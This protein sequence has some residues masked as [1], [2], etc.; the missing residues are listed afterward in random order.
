MRL[1]SGLVRE[2]ALRMACQE[3][4]HRSGQGVL[5]HVGQRLG[6]DDVVTMPGPQQ[7]EEV[8]PALAGR[9]AEP[10]EVVVADLRADAIHRL[11][12]RPGVVDRDP[13]RAR[14]P[15]PQH[16][17]ALLEE[18]PLTLDQQAHDLPLGD[19][20]P[21]R[22]QLRDQPRHGGLP[23]MVLGQHIAPQ[24]RPEVALH[25]ARQ[26]RH[27]QP[28]SRRQP[29]LAAAAHRLGPQHQILDQEVL[30]AVEPRAGRHRGAQHPLLDRHARLHLA[31]AAAGAVAR[32]LRL[33][34][35]LHAAR[36]D[37]WPA[38]QPLEAGDLLALRR[39][40]PLEFRHL[41]QQLDNQRLQLGR[42]KRVGVC[43]R[44]HAPDGIRPAATWE[45]QAAP[46]PQ[47]LPLL[48][49]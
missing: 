25:P 41:A 37:R 44:D 24:L 13:A 1:P 10:G 9:A 30:V 27:H 45:G 19:G 18:A 36:L 3:C 16:L 49:I 38:L 42:R 32:W 14:Q 31:A 29:P 8:Q 47:V 22:P 35:L 40:P 23:L 7:L 4:D 20:D 39:H 26:G 33:G 28:P 43:G 2:G 34:R 5:A 17:P 46:L 6:I 15:G 11:V 21:N 12:P 48:R